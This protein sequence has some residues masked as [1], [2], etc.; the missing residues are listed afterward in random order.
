LFS[1]LFR[2]AWHCSLAHRHRVCKLAPPRYAGAND[3]CTC[4]IDGDHLLVEFQ[5]TLAVGHEGFSYVADI[6][7]KNSEV[8]FI[9]RTQD[10]Q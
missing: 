5:G 3:T 6:G 2:V 9:N 4:G 8:R 1:V 10:D 7:D